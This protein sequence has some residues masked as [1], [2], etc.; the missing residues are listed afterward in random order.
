MKFNSQGGISILELLIYFPALIVAVIVC[1]R[2]GFGRSSGFIFTLILCLVRIVGACCQ[3]ATYQSETKGLIEAVLILDSIGI[4][5]LLL[6]TLGLLSRC[7]DSTATS[8]SG[9]FHAIQFRLIQLVITIGLILS[10]VGATSSVSPTGVYQPQA[11]T[12]VGVVLY[13]VAFVALV[14]IAAVISAKLSTSPGDD[15]KFSYAVVL[16]LP[17]ILVRL[18]YSL[19]SVFA[20]NSHFNLLTGSVIIHVFM[21]VLEEMAVVVIYL[22]VGWMTDALA[23]TA[24]GPIASRP[25]KGSLA[26]R[27]SSQGGNGRRKRQGPIHA[28]VGAGIAAVQQR[29]EEQSV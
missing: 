21:A 26:G 15:R 29:K 22:V 24:R 27:G 2:H 18:I 10:I 12:K 5:P 14:L 3:L 17:F 13:V 11:T 19:I 25:W 7:A 9:L 6:A 16:A 8:S 1:R 28:L 4:S 20:H 23:P